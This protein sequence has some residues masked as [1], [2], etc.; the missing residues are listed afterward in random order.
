MI[1][2]VA[3][4]R[5]AKLSDDEYLIRPDQFEDYQ[6]LMQDVQADKTLAGVIHGWTLSDSSTANSNVNS[7]DFWSLQKKSTVSLAWVSNA[8]GEV[9]I[10][11]A[12]S[13]N[14][15]TQGVANI[16]PAIE[17]Q[18]A[19]HCFVGA[20][21]V[22]QKEYRTIHTKIID[23]GSNVSA[24]IAEPMLGLSLIHI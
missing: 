7:H 5:Y 21:A 19:N 22:I 12:I 23:L 17:P 11:H 14:I 4:E 8:I 20:A 15:L 2:V 3:A 24:A 13:L 16:D 6:Q 10:E 18:P 1:S 9:V